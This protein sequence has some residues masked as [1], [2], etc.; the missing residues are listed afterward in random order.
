MSDV[1]SQLRRYAHMIQR[2]EGYVGK[3]AMNI[4][5]PEREE[6]ETL[7]EVCECRKGK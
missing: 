6:R 2:K 7:K 3:Q 5:L 1:D 4:E